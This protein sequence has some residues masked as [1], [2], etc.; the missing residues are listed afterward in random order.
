MKHPDYLKELL[1]I[2]L[3]LLPMAYLGI[4][5][6]QLPEELATN[7]MLNGTPEYVGYKGEF[8]LLMIFLFFTNLLLYF[9]FRYIPRLDSDPGTRES[10][11]GD[12]YYRIRFA[13]HIYLAVFSCF[14][15]LLLQLGYQ[16]GVEKWVFAGVGILIIVLGYYLGKVRPNYFVG[17]RTPR[18]LLDNEVWRRTHKM[19]GSLW[20]AVGAVMLVAGFFLPVMT[21]VFLVFVAVVL[22]SALPYIY[23]F[24]LY[25][26][27]KG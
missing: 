12:E 7:Y 8:L 24:R 5:W 11:N 21:G 26:R 18:T 14:V 10:L 1:L 20:I 23:S 15:I 9:L 4:I 19:A 6:N 2:C 22:L 27:D 3:L 25:N 16:R 17:V 13:I